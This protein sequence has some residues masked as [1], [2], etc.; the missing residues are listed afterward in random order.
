MM[1][2]DIETILVTRLRFMGDVILTTPVLAALRRAYPR[3]S[4]TYLAEWPYITLLEHHPAVDER[5]ALRR[6]RRFGSAEM[7]GRLLRR[8]FDL[9]IDLFGNP[10]SALLTFLSKASMRIGG[11]FRGRRTFYTHRIRDDGSRKT[12]VQFH[13]NYLDPLAITPPAPSDPEIALTDEEIAWSQDYLLRRG[14]DPEETIVGIH[15]GATWPAKRWFPHRFAVLANRLHREGAQILFTMGPGEDEVMESVL[16]SCQ[17]SV[18]EPHI[19]SLR[20]LGAILSRL[21]L[22]I[23]NDCGPMHLAPAVGTRTVGIFGPSDPGIWFPYRLEAGHVPV[24]KEVDCRICNR[25]WCDKMDCMRAI[26]VQD[27]LGAALDRLQKRSDSH[28][29]TAETDR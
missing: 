6:D 4:I 17:F 3:A 19:L 2:P 22:Y 11:D 7:I 12:A 20:Q 15:P 25:D 24:S 23:A 29:S 26:T 5:L 1:T 14:Y 18:I 10:R 16:R 27:V 28:G 8:R 9:A 21:D 13:L